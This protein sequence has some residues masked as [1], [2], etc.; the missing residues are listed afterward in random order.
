MVRQRN[1]LMVA[2]QTFMALLQRVASVESGHYE[3][4]DCTC[5]RCSGRSE[6][7][8]RHQSKHTIVDVTEQKLTC[9][10]YTV[11]RTLAVFI[12]LLN[13]LIIRQYSSPSSKGPQCV[14]MSTLVRWALVRGRNNLHSQQLAAIIDGWPRQGEWRLLTV[15][16]YYSNRSYI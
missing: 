1:T 8:M 4:A 7:G 15:R 2:E 5:H 12:C 9:F 16:G 11:I 14:H 10:L 6:H 13:M 3:R